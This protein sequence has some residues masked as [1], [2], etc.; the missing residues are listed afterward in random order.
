[1][2]YRALRGI[3]YVDGGGNPHRVEAGNTFNDMPDDALKQEIQDGNV[4]EVG[5]EDKPGKVITNVHNVDVYVDADYQEPQVVEPE[6]QVTIVEGS[7]LNAPA[8]PV[9]GQPS[10]IVE[11]FPE[12][13]KATVE[14]A[15]EEVGESHPETA[16]DGPEP[17]PVVEAPVTVV[18]PAS[19]AP[20]GE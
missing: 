8:E 18:P 3:D 13:N 20:S 19:D 7:P 17:V 12:E 5:S 14:P 4:V 9:P 11:G 2:D 16:V 6:P 15:Q 10:I 1:M